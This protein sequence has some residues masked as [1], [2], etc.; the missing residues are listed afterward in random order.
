VF[1][2]SCHEWF[3]F[4]SYAELYLKKM[5]LWWASYSRACLGPVNP[6]IKLP[7]KLCKIWGFHNG[8]YE[9]WCLLG[10]YAMWLLFLRSVRRLL[11][12]DS[13]VP[14]SQILVTLMKEALSSS[15][16]SVLTRATWRNIPEDTILPWKLFVYTRI[17]FWRNTKFDW[18]WSGNLVNE[19]HI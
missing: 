12:T 16:T 13:V 2:S 10:C 11:V 5:V 19:A 7:W 18:N 9:V 4:F 14:S 3:F 17:L 15:E 1:H 8:D 6:I